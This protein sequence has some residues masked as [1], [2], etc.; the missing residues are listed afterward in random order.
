MCRGRHSFRFVVRSVKDSAHTVV[1]YWWVSYTN[2]TMIL[3]SFISIKRKCECNG[4]GRGLRSLWVNDR[5]EQ[6]PFLWLNPSFLHSAIVIL[7]LSQ[8]SSS[9]PQG[10]EVNFTR[11]PPCCKD[12]PNPRSFANRTRRDSA[13][14]ETRLDDTTRQIIPRHWLIRRGNTNLSKSKTP[15]V[16]KN[17]Y[18][19]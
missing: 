1:S 11:A 9:A 13:V 8:R 7:P 14:S 16:W 4:M 6:L 15:S 18:H 12:L 10:P 17:Q 3:P 2:R 19:W 5:S